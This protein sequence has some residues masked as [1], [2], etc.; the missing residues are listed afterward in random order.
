[1][2]FCRQN[3]PSNR[4]HYYLITYQNFLCWTIS[5]N[6]NE[7]YNFSTN[8]PTARILIISVVPL[9]QS[10][11]NL[12]QIPRAQSKFTLSCTK[13]VVFFCIHLLVGLAK[14]AGTFF[15]SRSCPHGNL[16]SALILE[17]PCCQDSGYDQRSAERGPCVHPYTRHA[18]NK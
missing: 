6:N 13:K 10:Q 7:L 14:G 18:W 3:Q 12:N 17:W 2:C 8:H 1:M 15:P 5:K 16:R 11:R 4:Y 9:G